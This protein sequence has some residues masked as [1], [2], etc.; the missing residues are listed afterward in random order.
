[1]ERYDEYKD[2]GVD[3]I[4]EIPA[5]WDVRPIKYVATCNDDVLPEYTDADF[6]FHYV[7][8]SSVTTGKILRKEP[9]RFG[10]APSRARR[11]VQTNDVIVSTV[12]TYLRATATIIAEDE[13]CVVS[14]GFAVLRPRKINNKYFF[15]YLLSEQFTSAVVANSVGISYPAIN[16]SEL[17]RFPALIPSKAEQRLIGLWLDKKTE[18]IDSLIADCEREVELLQEYRK[19]VISEAVTRGLDPNVPMKDSGIEWIGEIPEAWSVAQLGKICDTRNGLDCS[20]DDVCD[21][22]SERATLV[23]RSGNVSAGK[24]L[25]D[26]CVYVNKSVPA[27]LLLKEGDVVVVRTNGSR[28]LVGKSAYIDRDNI[29]TLGAFMLLCR[30]RFGM[31]INWLFQSSMLSYYMG[32]FSTS[33]VNQLSNKTLQALHVPL[34]PLSEQHAIVACLDE[35]TAEIGALIADYQSMAKKLREYRKS[36]ISEA[37]TGKFKV[38]GLA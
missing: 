17:V 2:S 19:A 5:G 7:D 28:E 24:L 1:M 30:S 29:G 16:S 14:T 10:S 6:E 38:P 3:W 8:I 32:A 35:K 15:Y 20:S 13:D 33:T 9:C 4:G 36:L 25:L 23:I 37:V 18:A 11:L 31:F 12:R 21:E 22:G 34:P 26:E 27:S